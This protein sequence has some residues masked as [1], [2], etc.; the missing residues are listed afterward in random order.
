M[1]NKKLVSG[2][3]GQQAKR[4]ALAIAVVALAGC[5]LEVIDPNAPNEEDVITSAAG[6]RQVGVGLQAEYSNELVDPVYISG[7]VT[8]EIG[9]ILAAFESYRLIDAGLGIDND[10]GPSTET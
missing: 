7:L 5:D 2:A 9:A 1:T 10:L 3:V 8:D 4:F 6:L